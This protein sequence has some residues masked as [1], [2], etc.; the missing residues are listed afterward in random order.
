MLVFLRIAW[1]NVVAVL[2]AVAALAPPLLSRRRPLG[3]RTSAI[4]PQTARV[5]PFDGG[6]RA[7]NR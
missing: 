1:V 4:R 7:Q 2:G 3:I 5:I 6:R